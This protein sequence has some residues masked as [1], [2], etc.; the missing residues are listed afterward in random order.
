M[1]FYICKNIIG[2][3]HTWWENS[4]KAT[5]AKLHWKSRPSQAILLE[6]AWNKRNLIVI[7]AIYICKN[8]IDSIHTWWEN[9]TKATG[10]K[11]HWKPRPGQA[12]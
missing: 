4:T 12:I 7:N 8:K 3:I 11:L 9:I 2:S 1:Q 5:G 10:A 6:M